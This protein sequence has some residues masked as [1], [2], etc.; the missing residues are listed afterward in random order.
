MSARLTRI[1]GK[2]DCPV[3]SPSPFILGAKALRQIFKPQWHLCSPQRQMLRKKE[4]PLR[5]RSR[6][7]LLQDI[8]GRRPLRHADV[9]VTS[10]HWPAPRPAVPD[11]GPQPA[12]PRCAFVGAL[13]PLLTIASGSGW[14]HGRRRW[15]PAYPPHPCE[16]SGDVGGGHQQRGL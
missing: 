1:V 15:P 13:L 3:S 5:D 4:W 14:A 7:P 8:I 12:V 11:W 9:R 16:F 10:S 6:V 2:L